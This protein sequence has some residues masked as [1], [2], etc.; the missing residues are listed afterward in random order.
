MPDLGQSV[1]R[2]RL[3]VRGFRTMYYACRT[4]YPC[5]GCEQPPWMAFRNALG[6]AWRYR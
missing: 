4:D 2:V 5:E 6:W 1:S 3:F